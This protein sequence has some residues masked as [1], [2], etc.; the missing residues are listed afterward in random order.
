MFI[1]CLLKDRSREVNRFIFVVRLLYF[2]SFERL[3][4]DIM[5]KW[6]IIVMEVE[7]WD[8]GFKK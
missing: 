8:L 4:K 6:E 2:F 3:L 1:Y 7:F 5:S